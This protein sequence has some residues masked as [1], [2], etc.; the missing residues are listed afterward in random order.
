MELCQ[1][2]VTI[3]S[4]QTNHDLIGSEQL[5]LIYKF[6]LHTAEVNFYT[7]CSLCS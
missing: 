3:C 6:T 1:N 2:V 4:T 5:A 7:A